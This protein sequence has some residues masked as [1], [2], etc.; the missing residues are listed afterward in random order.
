MIDSESD[1]DSDSDS[2]SF[3]CKISSNY[4]PNLTQLSELYNA[5][6][7]GGTTPFLSRGPA[8]PDIPL[9]S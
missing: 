9:L 8:Q 7:K 1:S 5:Y 4:R 6:R 2:L 3:D